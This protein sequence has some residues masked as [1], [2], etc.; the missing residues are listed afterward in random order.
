L[1]VYLSSIVGSAS[2][3]VYSLATDSVVFIPSVVPLKKAERTA[4]WLKAMLIHTSISGSVLSGAFVCANSNGVLLPNSVQDGEL[5]EIRKHFENNVTIMETK[6]TAFGNLVL[7]NDF[8]AVVDPRF[9]EPQIKKI[10]DTLGVE[11]VPA[12]IAGLPYVGSLAVATNKGVLA[13]PLLKDE[14]RKLLENVFKVP[15]DVGSIN[16]GIPYV[17]TGLIANSRA[18]VAGSMTTGPEMFIIGNALDVVQDVE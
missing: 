3:G 2:I 4:E 5:V 9:K 7:T 11:A 14:E 13:H 12:E 17:G 8:G 10:S 15:V 1:A 16:C 18:A 6:K